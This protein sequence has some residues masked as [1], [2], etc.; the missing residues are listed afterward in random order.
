MSFTCFVS[1]ERLAQCCKFENP[2]QMRWDGIK[3]GWTSFEWLE[4]KSLGMMM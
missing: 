1:F 2:T 3:K 4:I